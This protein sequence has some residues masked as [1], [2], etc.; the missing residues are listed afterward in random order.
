MLKTVKKNAGV[1]IFFSLVLLLSIMIIDSVS[2]PLYGQRLVCGTRICICVCFDPQGI[3]K[4]DLKKNVS[5]YCYCP[6]GDTM[7]CDV[8]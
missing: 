3:C 8:W 7:R 6:N 5:C 4:C 2:L 1:I